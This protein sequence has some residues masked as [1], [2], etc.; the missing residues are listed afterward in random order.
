MK[1]I[2]SVSLLSLLLLG[3]VGASQILPS[4]DTSPQATAVASPAEGEA[5]D[6][7]YRTASAVSLSNVVEQMNYCYMAL[8]N[9]INSRS[10]LQYQTELDQLL[11]NLTIESIAGIDEIAS[12]RESLMA[13]TSDLSINEEERKVLRRVNSIRRDNAKYQALSNA[14]SIPMFLIPQN[15]G[16]APSAQLAFYALLTAARTAVDYT[17]QG[18]QQQAEELQSLWEIKKRDLEIYKNLRL[19][20]FRNLVQL[21]RKY[22]LKESDRLT[23]QTAQTFTNII[24][25]GNAAK[26]LRLLL[27]NERTYASLIDWEYY[28]GMAYADNKQVNEAYKHLRNY[29]VRRHATPL[30]RVDNKLGLAALALL[31]YNPK[32]DRESKLTYIKLAEE[33]LLDNGAGLSQIA[34]QYQLLGEPVPAFTLLRKGIDNEATTDKDLLVWSLIQ[35]I[36]Q[37]NKAPQVAKDFDQ[38][39]RMA[40]GLSV[41][42][43]L[44]YLVLDGDNGLAELKKVLTFE[45]FASRHFNPFDGLFWLGTPRLDYDNIKLRINSDN[46]QLRISDLSAYRMKISGRDAYITELTPV[47]KN[48]IKREKI[49]DELDFFKH[50][51]KAIPVIFATIEEG[52]IYQVRPEIDLREL[53]PGSKIADRLSAFGELTD[54]DLEDI[55]DFCED[56]PKQGGGIL[57]NLEDDISI[58]RENW[59]WSSF[60]KT[61]I[62]TANTEAWLR[63]KGGKTDE[64]PPAFDVRLLLS[65]DD[66]VH[67]GIPFVPQLPWRAKGDFIVLRWSGP[68]SLV[69]VYK[70][71]REERSMELYSVQFDEAK[72]RDGLLHNIG[73]TFIDKSVDLSQVPEQEGFWGAIAR[74]FKNLLPWWW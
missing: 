19:E 29:I 34:L 41:N 56:H 35:E 68:Q 59:L 54:E 39:I 8:T 20:A 36:G 66:P 72:G 50:N 18:N 71:N 70:H 1:K 43:Y 2:Y 55:R 37:L 49:E 45:D 27:D 6:S 64:E 3:G 57:L 25:E 4:G 17:M 13:A 10:M 5:S 62:P 61:Q 38:S 44:S 11:N 42:S 48:V 21:Y 30:F 32:M 33:N 74:F 7:V 15:G 22:N 53:V 14:L 69:L 16:T 40:S 23:E 31:S 46:L 47:Y 60:D 9:I 28:V 52:K 58:W 65:K 73:A 63:S 26:R 51:P 24:Q 12:I 67:A